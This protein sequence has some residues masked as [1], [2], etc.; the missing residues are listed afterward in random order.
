MEG[1]FAPDASQMPA[2]FVIAP[3]T[4]QME[5]N[6]V[7]SGKV[8]RQVRFGVRFHF[9]FLSLRVSKSLSVLLSR[10]DSKR[11]RRFL[12]LFGSDEV[13][14]PNGAASSSPGLARAAGLPW[15]GAPRDEQPQRGCGIGCAFLGSTPVGVEHSVATI[16]KVAAARQPWA[17]GLS[18]VGA[19]SR[20]RRSEREKTPKLPSL[21][22]QWPC[23]GG[24]GRGESK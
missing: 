22:S 15:V 8:G 2:D 1:D 23:S 13:M 24:E 6:A 11:R 5:D 16:P 20:R 21:L 18:P 10:G 7:Q 4:A 14:C 12:K 19:G 3:E 17:L 9:R